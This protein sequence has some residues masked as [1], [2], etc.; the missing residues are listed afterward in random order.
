M[1]K[2]RRSNFILS[3]CFCPWSQCSG[4]EWLIWCACGSLGRLTHFKRQ[5]IVFIIQRLFFLCKCFS[6]HAAHM[7]LAVDSSICD[8]CCSSSETEKTNNRRSESLQTFRFWIYLM[9]PVQ[10]GT[11]TSI[12]TMLNYNQ[13]NNEGNKWVSGNNSHITSRYKH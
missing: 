4:H 3:P 8:H 12:S 1:K 11:D 2:C 5:F 9:W 7:S 10:F 6:E 13:E